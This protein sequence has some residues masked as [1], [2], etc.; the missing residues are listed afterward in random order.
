MKMLW[1]TYL[2]LYL[3]RENQPTR[4]ILSVVIFLLF[5]FFL[6]YVRDTSFELGATADRANPSV[7]YRGHLCECS[8]WS[9]C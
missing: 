9:R 4:N 1:I 3:S 5:L 2:H 6:Q 8:N 7:L